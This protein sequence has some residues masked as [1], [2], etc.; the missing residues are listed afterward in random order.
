M[1]PY[2]V[3]A[4]VLIW[5]GSCAGSAW[6]GWDY[7]SAKF[8]QERQEAVDDALQKAGKQANADMAAA[9]ARTAEAAKAEE[10]AKKAKSAGVRDAATSAR[11]DCAR[12]AESLRLLN[13]AVDSSNPAT[14]PGGLSLKMS[15]T[16]QT[17]GRGGPDN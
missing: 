10:R 9:I 16:A 2:V 11:A 15:G 14:A 12:S 6:F 3:L 13:M 17:S 1:N 4:A 7:R 8:A 5:L